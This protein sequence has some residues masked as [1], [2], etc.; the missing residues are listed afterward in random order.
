VTVKDAGAYGLIV[1]QGHGTLNGRTIET[2]SMIR[3]GQ[4]TNDE[5]FASEA[6]ATG[7]VTIHNPSDSDPI[8]ILQHFGPGN[9]QKP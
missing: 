5:L 4:L 3:F 8:V 9:P 7:G 6:A 1:V 2:P